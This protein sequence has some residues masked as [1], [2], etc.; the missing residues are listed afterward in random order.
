[1]ATGFQA[2]RSQVLGVG[3]RVRGGP[4]EYDK[5]ESKGVFGAMSLESVSLIKAGTERE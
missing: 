2:G 1:M 5:P 3:M 4:G